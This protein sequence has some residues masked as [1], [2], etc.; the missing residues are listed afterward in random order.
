MKTCFIL[1]EFDSKTPTH[2][3]YTL[4]LFDHTAKN[5]PNTILFIEKTTRLPKTK[6]T[7]TVLAQKIHTKP[8][9]LLERLFILL[10]LRLSGTDT[11]FIHYSYWSLFLLKFISCFLPTKIIYWHA[12]KF[13]KK[14]IQALTATERIQLNLAIKL[15]PHLVTASTTLASGYSELFSKNPQKISIVS[16]WIDIPKTIKPINLHKQHS[17][18]KNKKIILFVHRLSQRKGAHLLPKII[19]KVTSQNRDVFF[20]IIGSG[21]LANQLKNQFDPK[22]AKLVGPVPQPQIL[23]YFHSSD[24]FIMPSLREGF[25]RVILEGMATKTPFVATTAG[26]TLEITPK[27]QHQY[28]SKPGDIESFQKLVLTRLKNKDPQAIN[29]CFRKVKTYNLNDASRSLTKTIKTIKTPQ[30]IITP[31][32]ALIFLLVATFYLL[33]LPQQKLENTLGQKYQGI[34]F[35]QTDVD[36]YYLGR[37]QKAS[38]GYNQLS[39]STLLEETQKP[40]LIPRGAEFTL[41]KISSIVNLSPHKLIL[42]LKPIIPLVLITL[43]FFTGLNLG[44]PWLLSLV[45]A[46]IIIVTPELIHSPTQL[47]SARNL[48]PI[49]SR[50]VHPSFSFVPFS[51]FLLFLSFFKKTQS[52]TALFGALLF[53][54]LLWYFYLYFAIFAGVLFG[55]VVALR[56]LTQK[57]LT[58]LFFFLIYLL[59]STPYL[60]HNL[61]LQ[62]NPEFLAVGP[63]LGTFESR[64]PVL[65]LQA[66]CLLILAL[67]FYHSKKFPLWPSLL[68]LSYLIT[69]N[70][71]L[72][73]G[74]TVQPGHWSLYVLPFVSLYTFTLIVIRLQSFR[75]FLQ[76]TA[77]ILMVVLIFRVYLN[78]TYTFKSHKNLYTNLQ[79]MAPGL[80]WLDQNADLDSVI[81]APMDLAPLVSAYTNH[82][83]YYSPYD[84]T[85]WAKNER[86]VHNWLVHMRL[87]DVLPS[88]A[89]SYLN[90][91]RSRVSEYVFGLTYLV[92][93]QDFAAIEDEKLLS[94]ASKYSDFYS[95]PLINNL[96]KYQIDYVIIPNHD[97]FLHLIDGKNVYLDKF[98]TILEI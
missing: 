45:L 14:E 67:V 32:F 37:V 16:N 74:I 64:T 98:V 89:Y 96:K 62:T 78:Q 29:E 70:Q 80:T 59:F 4:K 81:L 13:T 76:P 55:L 12:E 60:I 97:S 75:K 90:L 41:G 56:S 82:F 93:N 18:P 22:F 17:I 51:I 43:L 69:I 30:A 34:H 61:N 36:N 21:P 38:L 40:P 87:N 3:L 57:S 48:E 73:S 63:R 85:T 24:L 66:L 35:S 25:P 94:L 2:F 46:F 49:F 28:L 84:F 7:K 86:L 65:S 95:Q 26:S 83:N 50:P 92:L 20:L 58:P 5:L 1:P 79:T 42:F 71:H 6:H 77:L 72:L 33:K 8:F 47:F 10:K 53:A 15:A 31:I 11:F 23:S 39:S 88:Q 91:N 9:N 44:F 68:P 19:Q 54:A 52:K 27:L